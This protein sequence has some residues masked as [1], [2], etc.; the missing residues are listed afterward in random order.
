M[1]DRAS[2]IT[3]ISDMTFGGATTLRVSGA[4][5]LAYTAVRLELLPLGFAPLLALAVIV[6]LVQLE[7]RLLDRQKVRYLQQ[8]GRF[9]DVEIHALVYVKDEDW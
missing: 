3:R 4:L 8:D 1:T 6:G 7:T 5:A 9:T 2:A